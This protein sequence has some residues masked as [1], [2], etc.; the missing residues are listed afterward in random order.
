MTDRRGGPR[1][2]PAEVTTGSPRQFLGGWTSLSSLDTRAEGGRRNAS[3]QTHVGPAVGRDSRRGHVVTR[4][5]LS[6]RRPAVRNQRVLRRPADHRS[7]YGSGDVR[8]FLGIGPA[9][10][11]AVDP[12]TGIMYAG[13]G[14][15]FAALFT[16]DPSTGAA[17][18]VGDTG[19][20]FA[21]VGALDFS[22]DGTLYAAVN[23]VG[24]GGTGSD[25]LAVIDKATGAATVIGP[26]GVCSS[27][28]FGS[29]TIEGMEAI[30]FDKAGLLWGAHS[31]RGAAGPPRPLPDQPGHG[32]GG[33]RGPDSGQVREPAVRWCGQPAVRV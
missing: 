19:L 1:R 27:F 29:C 4:L 32:C 8:R 20:G 33:V 25:H 3:F 18:F 21:A 5:G 12:T 11:L 17:T 9:P 15:G 30:A 13:S 24:A 6:R 2:R 16:V 28:P 31:A 26:F 23:I 14:G 7:Q 22:A 10:S